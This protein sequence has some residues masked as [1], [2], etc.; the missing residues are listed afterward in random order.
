MDVNKCL[1]VADN[2]SSIVPKV[3]DFGRVKTIMDALERNMEMVSAKKADISIQLELEEQR[4]G[5]KRKREVDLWIQRAGSMEDRVH[6]LGRK[7]KETHFLLRFMLASQ[8]ISLWTELNILH[9]KGR[10]DHG[11]TQVVKPARGYEL[12]PG[13]LVGQA[14]QT[15][16]NE[17]WDRLMKE[18]VPGMGVWGQEGAGKTFLAKHIHDR[19]VRDCPRF[20]G[21]CLVNVSQEG[22]IGTI[23]TDIA[24]YLELDLTAVSAVYWGARLREALQGKRLLIILDDVGRPYSLEEVGITLARDGCKLIVTSRSREVCKQMNCHELVHVPHWSEEERWL[25]YEAVDD[26]AWER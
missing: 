3:K 21:A 23:Q 16:S 10:F 12:R 2:L 9:E 1:G 18:E 20:D 6:K 15:K 8:V 24:K 25:G 5:K 19:I 11:L 22:T 14:S 17:I 7:V 26:Y 13:E 4:P